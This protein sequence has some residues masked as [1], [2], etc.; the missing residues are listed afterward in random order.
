MKIFKEQWAGLG[1]AFDLALVKGDMELAGAVWR[2]F[3]GARGA[4]G[5]I[6]ADPQTKPY[7]RRSVNLVG[8]SDAAVKE[9][10]RKGLQAE[11]SRDDKSG[12]HDFP[13]EMADEYVAFPETMFTLV[14]Y[15]RRE[16]VRLENLPNSVIQEG[17]VKDIKFGALTGGA[18]DK[19]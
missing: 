17:P 2:N 14:E 16:L 7:F 3:L 11:E 15:V 13:P 12:V 8:G 18:R 19:V 4:C 9:L 5:I 1:M 6:Y 10:D